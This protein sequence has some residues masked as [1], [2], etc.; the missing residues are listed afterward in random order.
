M[1]IT[2]IVVMALRVYTYTYVKIIKLHVFKNGHFIV[3]QLY[4]CKLARMNM[5]Q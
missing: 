4:L 1:S 3:H 2:L 5:Y